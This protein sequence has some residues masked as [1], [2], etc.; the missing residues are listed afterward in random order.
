MLFVNRE[1]LDKNSTLLVET[2]SCQFY[3]PYILTIDLSHVSF[4][5]LKKSG[6]NHFWGF[7]NFTKF[8]AFFKVI[9]ALFTLNISL[10]N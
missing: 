6:P 3:L 2:I 1:L 5:N 9:S 7:I 8:L 10:L 4:V